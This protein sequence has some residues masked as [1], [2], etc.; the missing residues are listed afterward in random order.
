MTN[1]IF[2]KILFVSIGIVFIV[3]YFTQLIRYMYLATTIKTNNKGIKELKYQEYNP[4]W[5]KY[6]MR[7]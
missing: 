3:N 4:T 5:N 2:L 1:L 6:V 7:R